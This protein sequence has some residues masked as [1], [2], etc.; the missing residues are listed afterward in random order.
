MKI[1]VVGEGDEDSDSVYERL[2]ELKTSGKFTGTLE[3][4][5]NVE[6]IRRRGLYHN[7]VIIINDIFL[8][9]II[10]ES[11]EELLKKIDKYK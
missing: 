4:I 9:N 1:Q 11:N 8:I 6:P 7:L 10:P 5:R 3:Y 2:Y